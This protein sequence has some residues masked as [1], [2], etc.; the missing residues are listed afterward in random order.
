MILHGSCSE[1]LWVAVQAV[2]ILLR[3]HNATVSIFA[4]S[5]VPD[6]FRGTEDPS[7]EKFLNHML[8]PCFISEEPPDYFPQWLQPFYILT[9]NA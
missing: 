2:F 8:I 4:L 6:G 1:P 5:L 7:E 3:V 9:S